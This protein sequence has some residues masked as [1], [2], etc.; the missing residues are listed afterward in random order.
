[1]ARTIAG[2]LR[3][4][5]DKPLLLLRKVVERLGTEQALAFLKETLEIG[6]CGW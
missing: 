2:Q 5:E 6:V 4:T 3:E 1:M